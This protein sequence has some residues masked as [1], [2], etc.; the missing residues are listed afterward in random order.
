MFSLTEA[1]FDVYAL[2]LPDFRSRESAENP[3]L[4]TLGFEVCHR[5]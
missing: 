4:K 1:R 5:D 3:W 2:D